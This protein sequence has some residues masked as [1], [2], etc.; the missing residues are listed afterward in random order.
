MSGCHPRVSPYRQSA[1]IRPVAMRRSRLERPCAP[2]LVMD[3]GVG[4]R[5]AR[6]APEIPS[7]HGL[8]PCALPQ[9]LS[10]R[11]AAVCLQARRAAPTRGLCAGPTSGF[12]AAS[13]AKRVS[14]QDRSCRGALQLRSCGAETQGPLVPSGLMSNQVRVPGEARTCP[15]KGTLQITSHAS[16]RRHCSICCGSPIEQACLRALTRPRCGLACLQAACRAGRLCLQRPPC[17]HASRNR[18]SSSSCHCRPMVRRT[19]GLKRMTCSDVL[20]TPWRVAA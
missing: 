17:L 7:P 4:R 8:K 14:V 13:S 9:S 6:D 20:R 3:R 19:S 18:H 15:C 1:S 11:P 2:A 12:E 10:V 16:G 5:L